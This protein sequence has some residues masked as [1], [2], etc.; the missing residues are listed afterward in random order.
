MSVLRAQLNANHC[1]HQHQTPSPSHLLWI[2]QY[3]MKIKKNAW[4]IFLS[5]V[6]WIVMLI[7]YHFPCPIRSVVR[8]HLNE[9][10]ALCFENGYF[11]VREMLEIACVWAMR[12]CKM[13]FCHIPIFIRFS[14][15]EWHLF[16]PIKFSLQLMKFNRFNAIKSNDG[17]VYTNTKPLSCSWCRRL[18]QNAHK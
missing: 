13:R 17:I 5:F 15:K 3:E 2:W 12:T 6:C 10:N 16:L 11:N 8:K 14:T 4:N 1:R 18:H 9:V 7:D